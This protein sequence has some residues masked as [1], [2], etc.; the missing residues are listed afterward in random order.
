MLMLRI[1]RA[2]VVTRNRQMCIGMNNTACIAMHIY[3]KYTHYTDGC[4]P[5]D[6]HMDMY[7]HVWTCVWTAAPLKIAS[8]EFHPLAS[9]HIALA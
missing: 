7:G 4:I 2:Q 6:M 1:C 5:A 9:D 8:N 3:S